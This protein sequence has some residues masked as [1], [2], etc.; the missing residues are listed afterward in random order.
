M[1]QLLFDLYKIWKEVKPIYTA[2]KFKDTSLVKALQHSGEV[3]K[4][5]E[6]YGKA[7]SAADKEA[8]KKDLD[9]VIAGLQKLMAGPATPK[10]AKP[11]DIPQKA[12]EVLA[13]LQAAE[14]AR[15]EMHRIWWAMDEGKL[16]VDS[17]TSWQQRRRGLVTVQRGFY[18]LAI[19]LGG[20]IRTYQG[21][22]NAVQDAQTQARRV[23]VE[24]KKIND[25]SAA[26][27]VKMLEADYDDFVEQEQ[28]LKSTQ[29]RFQAVEAW[30][31]K[32]H[33]RLAETIKAGDLLHEKK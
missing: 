15:Q 2:Y 31:S 17:A 11:K 20:L 32:Q 26:E 23:Y 10:A 22:I 30:A 7:R 25:A 9:T 14:F 4:L 19:Q 12:V 21:D 18:D 33:A 16:P 13:D 8:V 28:E 27:Q 6:R 24:V 29:R 5:I 1:I 3:D